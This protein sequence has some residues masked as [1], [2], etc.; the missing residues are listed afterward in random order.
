MIF[1]SCSKIHHSIYLEVRIGRFPHEV[2]EAPVRVRV[3]E[4]D[5][6]AVPRPSLLGDHPP[7]LADGPAVAEYEL[8]GHPGEED[9]ALVVGDVGVYGG[10]DGAG[11]EDA[12]DGNGLFGVLSAADDYDVGGLYLSEFQLG[13]HLDGRGPDGAAGFYETSLSVHL[14]WNIE[15]V[16]LKRK[17]LP[18]DTKHH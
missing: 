16:G 3:S 14:G 13:G 11:E 6:L 1:S 15:A 2:L 4:D 18:L 17:V 8:G 9:G 5:D 12:E 7:H 10:D